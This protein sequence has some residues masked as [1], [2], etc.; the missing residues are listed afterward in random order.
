MDNLLNN[1]RSKC[2]LVCHTHIGS[3]CAVWDPFGGCARSGLFEHTINLLKGQALGL[4]NEDVCVE[5][6]QSTER[7]PDEEYA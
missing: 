4:R 5:E 2:T 1:V 6:A 7:S 3:E